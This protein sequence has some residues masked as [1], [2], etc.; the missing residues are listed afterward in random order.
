LSVPDIR[1]PSR[2]G[3]PHAPMANG[4]H[5]AARAAATGLVLRRTHVFHGERRRGALKGY[6]HEGRR[7]RHAV[8]Q[9]VVSPNAHGV[10]KA[11]W[12]GFGKTGKGKLSSFFPKAWTQAEVEDAIRLAVGLAI[13]TNGLTV[14]RS[15]SRWKFLEVVRGIRIE[16]LL[17][18]S[19]RTIM[20]AY[21]LM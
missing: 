21:P 1:V 5:A 15:G 17:S 20:T 18:W 13:V 14:F 9:V 6:H 19:G 11:R 7:P 10:Y 4:Q 2:S 8:T 3:R 16:G 12:I